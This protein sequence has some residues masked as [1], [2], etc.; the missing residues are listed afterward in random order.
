MKTLDAE[1]LK[2]HK[3]N[4]HAEFE[5]VKKEAVSYEELIA[6]IQAKHQDC[7]K[8]MVGLKG[9]FKTITDLERQIGAES[10][11]PGNEQ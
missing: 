1:A 9:A 6:T 4:L 2:V 8:K 7:L 10:T 11:L 5:Q 3:E